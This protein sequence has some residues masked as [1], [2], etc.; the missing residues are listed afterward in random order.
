MEQLLLL[1]TQIVPCSGGIPG[2]PLPA[3]ASDPG[4]AGVPGESCL[5]RIFLVSVVLLL[6]PK[7]PRTWETI[8]SKWGDR[9][10]D[11]ET[12]FSGRAGSYSLYS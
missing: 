4:Q 8:S 1:G 10:H 5:Q 3:E 12:T 2:G 7:K 9:G 6:D 11:R